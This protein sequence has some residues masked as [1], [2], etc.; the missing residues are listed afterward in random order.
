MIFIKPGKKA[1]IDF[2]IGSVLFYLGI[3]AVL[4]VIQRSFIYFP[5]Q[6]KP[7]LTQYN[8][9]DMDVVIVRT[10]DG[11]MLEGWYSLPDEHK[12]VI[13]MFHGNAIH[14]G[15]RVFKARPYMDAGYA[16][17]LA[18]YRG[19]G[20]NPGDPTEQG[21]YKDGR[22][23]IDWLKNKQGI[24]E[25]NIILYG[26]SLGS[27]VVIQMATE[28]PD[29]KAIILE[30]PYTTL[31]DVAK[32]IYFFVPVKLLM[33]DRYRNIDKIAEVKAPLIVLHGR[34]DNVVPYKLG[35]RLFE[36]A[37]EPKHMI[38]VPIAGHNDLYNRGAAEKVL[39]LLA[40]IEQDR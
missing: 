9:D 10:D 13:V 15:V 5:A 31:P 18:G 20:G 21:L 8:A 12:P 38:T 39:E 6:Q 19:Y 17:L 24:P 33:K 4:Y 7:S 1:V 22:A 23:Y 2:L 25:S 11:L 30:A 32:R 14:Q 34:L 37:S 40:K 3:L 27:G 16:F 35:R 29:I 36:A 26:E 28:Y